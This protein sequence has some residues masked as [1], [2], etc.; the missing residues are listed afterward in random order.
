[1]RID[2]L[3]IFLLVLSTALISCSAMGVPAT[4]DP[5]KKLDYAYK[6]IQHQG[7]PLPAER[8]IRE[9]I[10]I[11]S[12]EQNEKVLMKAYWT[13]GIFFRSKAVGDLKGLYEKDGFLDKTAKFENRF[14]NSIAYFDKAESIVYIVVFSFFSC[15][16]SF[17]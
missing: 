15:Y 1:M 16:V 9:A 4:S 7:R 12:N 11:G 13:Y 17:M 8:L 5:N 10:E 3:K 6:L 2:I 14:E